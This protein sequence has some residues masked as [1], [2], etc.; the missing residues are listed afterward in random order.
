MASQISHLVKIVADIAIALE[1]TDEMLLNPDVAIEM[2][3]SIAGSLQSLEKI[4]QEEIASAF[5]TISSLY[6]AEL[7]EFVHALPAS[8]GIK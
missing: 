4:D 3:E 5:E 8:Y 6:P 7:A 2:Q 1:F